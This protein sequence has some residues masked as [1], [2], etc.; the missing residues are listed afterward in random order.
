MARNTARKKL[1]ARR[2]ASTRLENEIKKASSA[3]TKG[4]FKTISAASSHFQIPY[5]MLRRRHLGLTE[6]KLTAHSKQQLLTVV[7]EE[8]LCK[9]IKYMGMTGHPFSREALRVKVAEISLLLQEKQTR[10]GE[11]QLP[12]RNWTYS[13]IARHPDLDFKR[14]TGLDPKRAQNFNPTVVKHHFQLLGNFL[15]EYDIPW[16]NVYNMDEKGIQLGGGRKLDNT[17]YYYP[18]SQRNRVQ[19]QSADLELVTTIECIGADGSI[20]RPGY[21]FPGKHVLYDEYFEED[22]VL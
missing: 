5:H 16:E 4:T 3:L 11:V 12:S 1:A 6:Q 21:V 13:F 9:W 14:P 22:D 18:E 8:T 10:T 2:D 20:L 19:I 15:A 17:K 7:E